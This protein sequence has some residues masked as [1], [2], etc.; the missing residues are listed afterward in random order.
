MPNISI[1]P[2]NKAENIH[3]YDIWGQKIFLE[4]KLNLLGGEGNDPH[5]TN[6]LK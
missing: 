4:W 1:V 3:D 2:Q 6:G 5:V